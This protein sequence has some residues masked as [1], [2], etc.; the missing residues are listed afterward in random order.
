MSILRR[1]LVSVGGGFLQTAALAQSLADLILGD[2]NS[3]GDLFRR[4]QFD[5]RG[6]GRRRSADDRGQHDLELPRV[7][8]HPA[9]EVFRHRP[10][11]GWRGQ[12]YTCSKGFRSPIIAALRAQKT[13]CGKNVGTRFSLGNFE[14]REPIFIFSEGSIGAHG[15]SLSAGFP[16]FPPRLAGLNFNLL[17]Q[18]AK[19]LGDNCNLTI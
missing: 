8:A 3:D 16:D 17:Q 12:G 19:R 11:R 1:L 14:S 6:L 5:V 15:A 7:D 4:E 13:S 9:F 10:D 18:F 2:A